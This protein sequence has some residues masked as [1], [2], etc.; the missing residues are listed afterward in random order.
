[1]FADTLHN[2]Y[3]MCVMLLFNPV[4]TIE[5][6]TY[7]AGLYSNHQNVL[8]WVHSRFRNSNLRHTQF[9]TYLIIERKH[10]YCITSFTNNNYYNTL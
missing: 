10:H 2:C 7:L 9:H 5:Y 4:T 6:S 8:V 3:D 1:M